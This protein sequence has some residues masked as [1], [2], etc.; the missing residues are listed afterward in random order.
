MAE[1]IQHGAFENLP[2][3]TVACVLFFGSII[4]TTVAMAAKAFLTED[5]RGMWK[6][7]VSLVACSQ[8]II[9]FS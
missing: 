2:P 3:S 6:H 4:F 1:V 7:A 5:G 9:S 8:Q